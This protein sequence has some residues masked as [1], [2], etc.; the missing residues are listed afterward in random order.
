MDKIMCIS[1]T[2]G[3]VEF[4]ESVPEDHSHRRMV[5]QEVKMR[6]LAWT[7]SVAGFAP[8]DPYRI[9]KQ[10]GGNAGPAG[11][12]IA[13]REI[14]CA[15]WRWF[16]RYIHV[17]EQAAKGGEVGSAGRKEAKGS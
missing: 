1:A 5:Q 9:S 17:M 4:L 15:R 11:T 8:T 12:H 14:S 3:C 13:A 16:R 6:I 10:I 7:A 2:N